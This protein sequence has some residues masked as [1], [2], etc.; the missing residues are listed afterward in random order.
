MSIPHQLDLQGT[1][2]ALEVFRAAGHAEVDTAIM[3]EGGQTEKTLGEKKKRGL[4]RVGGGTHAR[5]HAGKNKKPQQPHSCCFSIRY[6]TN[7]KCPSMEGWV[8][9][10]SFFF[11]FCK[12]QHGGK[13][14]LHLKTIAS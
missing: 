9:I 10:Q 2:Q 13:K 7:E 4:L 11:F 12:V 5:T 8:C 6:L 3:Y 1:V 14:L